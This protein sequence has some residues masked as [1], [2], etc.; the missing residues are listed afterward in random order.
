M[1]FFVF[2][3]SQLPNPVVFNTIVAHQPG[4]VFG[5]WNLANNNGEFRLYLVRAFPRLRLRR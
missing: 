1:A 3:S 2:W 4:W 5:C